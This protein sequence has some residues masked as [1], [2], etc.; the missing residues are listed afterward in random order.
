MKR[1]KV[2]FV[3]ETGVGKTTLATVLATGRPPDAS[4]MTVGADFHVLRDAESDVTLVM[5]D[6]AG[7]ER[8]R[9]LAPGIAKGAD[10][11]VAV[12]DVSKPS[13]LSL[14]GDWSEVLNQEGVKIVLVGNKLD[15]GPS[16]GPEDVRRVAESLN[17]REVVLVSALYG[18]NV[19]KLKE[20]LIRIALS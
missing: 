9:H 13:T 5:F 2:V 7:Q 11:V 4:A 1:V 3:G 10:V 18:H 19:E 17:A 12:F 16:V 6:L 14:L 20:T 8:F 15:L